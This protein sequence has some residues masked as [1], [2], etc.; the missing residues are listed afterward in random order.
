MD[1]VGFGV[2]AAGLWLFVAVT[3]GDA[4]K[5]R[6]AGCGMVSVSEGCG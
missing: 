3:D 1:G 6:C 5:H 2:D 4:R